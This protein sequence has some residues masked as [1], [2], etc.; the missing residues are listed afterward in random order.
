MLCVLTDKECESDEIKYH[1]QVIHKGE[2]G[3]LLSY[4]IEEKDEYDI[5]IFINNRRV[6]AVMLN[7]SKESDIKLIE[8]IVIIIL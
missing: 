1:L 4:G 7:G 3:A 8:I 6:K 5:G 2:Q